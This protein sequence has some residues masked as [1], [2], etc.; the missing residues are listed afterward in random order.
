[1]IRRV[2]THRKTWLTPLPGLSKDFAAG[3]LRL[4]CI[5]IQNKELLRAMSSMAVFHWPAGPSEKIALTMLEDEE[6]LTRFFEESREALAEANRFSRNLLDEAGV[7]FVT[8]SNPLS[9]RPS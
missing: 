4:G 2:A 3:G 6:W 1:V 8:A 5:Y 7:R 9:W